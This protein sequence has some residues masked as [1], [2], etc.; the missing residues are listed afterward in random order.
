MHVLGFF[1]CAFWLVCC[2]GFPRIGYEEQSSLK[3]PEIC[4]LL[5]LDFLGLVWFVS[6]K[7]SHSPDQPQTHCVAKDD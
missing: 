7:W 1:C 6:E 5:K 4:L 2:T 3:L